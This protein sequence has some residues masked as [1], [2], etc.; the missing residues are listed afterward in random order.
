MLVRKGEC[1]ITKRALTEL[2]HRGSCD[3]SCGLNSIWQIHIPDCSSD[4]SLTGSAAINLRFKCR[5]IIPRPDVK[6]HKS[7]VKRCGDG[8]FHY[9]GGVCVSCK[10]LCKD[11]KGDERHK[12]GRPNKEKTA[13]ELKKSINSARDN[14]EKNN[15]TLTWTLNSMVISGTN[16]L[17]TY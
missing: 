3:L 14:N 13:R 15:V 10:H 4:R 17:S 5:F 7:R 8:M 1:R 2:N 16:L 11:R 6:A 12:N 9:I